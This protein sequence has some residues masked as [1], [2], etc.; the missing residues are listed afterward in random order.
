[1][2]FRNL[3]AP[4][5]RCTVKFSDATTDSLFDANNGKSRF[6]IDFTAVTFSAS[7]HYFLP[8]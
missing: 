6:A 4:P 5:A 3:Q 8:I 2:H 1:M 7:Y